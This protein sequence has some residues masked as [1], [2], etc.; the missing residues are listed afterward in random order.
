MI[1][2]SQH[3]KRTRGLSKPEFVGDGMVALNGKTCH[4]WGHNEN[5]PTYKTR[6]KG[7]NKQKN[8]LSKEHSVSVM[9]TRIPEVVVSSGFIK[10]NLIIKTYKQKNIGLSSYYVRRKVLPNG[11]RTTHLLGI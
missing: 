10:D 1:A 9:D 3:Q 4:I 11:R 8:N 7:I 6:T 5:R 2:K